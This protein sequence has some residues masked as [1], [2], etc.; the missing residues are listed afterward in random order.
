MQLRDSFPLRSYLGLSE[1]GVGFGLVGAVAGANVASKATG[2]HA[3]A[4]TID[5]ALSRRC[6]RK[7]RRFTR[8]R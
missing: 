4:P 8:S 1:L 3:L 5:I 2:V 6:G 7:R